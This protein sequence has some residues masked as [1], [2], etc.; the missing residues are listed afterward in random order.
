MKSDSGYPAD[1]ML[2]ISPRWDELESQG[3]IKTIED[4]V[5]YALRFPDL[6][7]VWPLGYDY[8]EHQAVW[9]NLADKNKYL[10]LIAPNDHGKTVTLSIAYPLYRMAQ[11]KNIRIGLIGH[12]EDLPK[13]CMREIQDQL[14]RNEDLKYFGLRKPKR[15]KKWSD[16]EIIIDR[17]GY[18]GL[19][20]ATLCALGYRGSLASRRMD[21]CILDDVIDIK[22]YES[23]TDL[24]PERIKSWLTQTLW[25]RLGDKGE[26]KIIGTFQSHG[27][28]Y[29]WLYSGENRDGRKMNE[30]FSCWRF[31]SLIQRGEIFCEKAGIEV[32]KEKEGENDGTQ[33]LSE[34]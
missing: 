33:A 5:N 4:R 10:L 19:K 6:F 12:T 18:R 14:E 11:N 31:R 27:D 24:L 15:P 25:T 2:K 21:L 34:H 20:D 26:I 9:L 32:L 8:A 23:G 30:V 22:D 1:E 3:K 28:L 7:H 17:P 13:I 16:T 29:N